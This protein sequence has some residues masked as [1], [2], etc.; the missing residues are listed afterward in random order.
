MYAL[1]QEQ[2]PSLQS[3][4][5]AAAKETTRKEFHLANRHFVL[6]CPMPVRRCEQKPRYICC[7]QL[8]RHSPYHET[9]SLTALPS[10][11]KKNHCHRLFQAPQLQRQSSGDLERY[12]AIQLRQNSLACNCVLSGS[13]VERWLKSKMGAANHCLYSTASLSAL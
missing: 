13:L 8:I 9:A 2:L 7:V 11:N 1:P 5:T 4:E 10:M 12:L 3:K 6:F